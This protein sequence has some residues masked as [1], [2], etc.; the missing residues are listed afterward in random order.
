MKMSFDEQAKKEVTT[1]FISDLAEMNTH[2]D[3]L[4][5]E[6]RVWASE[7]GYHQYIAAYEKFRAIHTEDMKNGTMKLYQY[8]KQSDASIA[9]LL[10]E[11]KAVPEDL[12][13]PLASEF[14]APIEDALRNAFNDTPDPLKEEGTVHFTRTLEEDNVLLQEMLDDCF[15]NLDQMFYD[16][17][18]QYEYLSIDNQLYA[19]VGA[20]TRSIL[21]TASNLYDR[22]AK[23]AEELGIHLNDRARK[24][25]AKAEDGAASLKNSSEDLVS[26]LDKLIGL[27]E[28]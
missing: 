5:E 14:E 16:V 23:A 8:W 22:F 7:E 28:D 9:T 15:D 10:K 26:R 13:R 20:L 27:L 4:F 6:M 25:A 2:I 11:M 17:Q 3:V 21:S 18:Y 24:T 19:C 1:R 12:V